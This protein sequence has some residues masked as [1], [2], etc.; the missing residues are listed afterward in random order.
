ME[1]V[2]LVDGTTRRK[3]SFCRDIGQKMEVAWVA[4]EEEEGTQIVS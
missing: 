4:E 3:L 1:I 2:C